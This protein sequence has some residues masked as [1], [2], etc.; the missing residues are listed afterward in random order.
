M[1]RSICVTTFL[2]AVPAFAQLSASGG[3]ASVA[4]PAGTAPIRWPDVAYDATDDVFLGVSGSGAVLGQY[5]T[6]AGAASGA[7]FAVN[8]GTVFGQ[9]PRT[10]WAPDVGAFLVGW[11][12]TIGN[13]TRIRGRLIRHGKTALTNDFDLSA[14]GT[15]WEMGAAMAYA[16]VSKEFLVAWQDRAT[17]QIHFQRVS[18][19]GG[20][21]GAVV[22]VEAAAYSRD[23]SVGYDPH[24]DRF[25]VAYGGCVGNDDCFIH[26]QR[27]QAGTGAKVGAPIVVDAPV[28]AGYVPEVAYNAVTRQFLVVWYRLTG[29]ANSGLHGKLIDATGTA[30]TLLPILP[31]AGSYDANSVAWNPISNT[32]AVVSHGSTSQDVMI[33]VSATGQVGQPSGVMFGA[34]AS[35]GNFNPRVAASMTTAG[36]LA[37]TSSAFTSFGAQRVNTATRDATGRGD[38]GVPDSG[39]ADSGVP[40]SG[41]ADAGIPDAGVPDSG[42]LDAGASDA[43]SAALDAGTAMVAVGSCGCSS[44]SAPALLGLLLLAHFISGR[45][46]AAARRCTD[47]AFRPAC[48]RRT[49]SGRP[50]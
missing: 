17:T 36:W 5:F 32:F 6:A 31:G 37:V 35:S 41:V 3:L 34:A 50:D 30:G 7:S 44:A 18:N 2:L 29:G 38:A 48:R 1:L 9:A 15:N 19:G 16:T 4:P 14:F 42:T 28:K 8:S 21:L 43:G 20:L 22:T 45:R 24:T 12:E 23:P 47:A 26:A 40:D 13:D 49:I 10:A 11:H 39:I 25:L 33:E 27:I 46:A